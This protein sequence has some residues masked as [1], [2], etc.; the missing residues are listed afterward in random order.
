[1]CVYG[2]T[3]CICG[4][5]VM[6]LLFTVW[7]LDRSFDVRMTGNGH[8]CLIMAPWIEDIDVRMCFSLDR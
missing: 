2:V 1:M 7:S 4:G 5:G 6:G 3:V 8:Q